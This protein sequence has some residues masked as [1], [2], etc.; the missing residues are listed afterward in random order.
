MITLQS[1]QHAAFDRFPQLLRDLAEEFGSEG[2]SAVADRFIAAEL[3]DFYWDGR[4]AEMSLGT[5]SDGFNEEEEPL[6]QVGIIGYFRGRYYV[7]TCL[8]DDE[9]R[10]RWMLRVQHFDDFAS[11]ETAFRAAG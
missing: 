11:A 7:A 2:I 6:Q 8:V 3:A 5:H 10:V 9:R 1:H 4:I